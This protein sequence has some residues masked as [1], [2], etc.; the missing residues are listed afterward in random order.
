MTTITLSSHPAISS[1]ETS[2]STTTV[3]S[4]I[5]GVTLKGTAA[6]AYLFGQALRTADGTYFGEAGQR[7]IAREAAA[8]EFPPDSGVRVSLNEVA[9]ALRYK[10]S[11][12]PLIEWSADL[13]LVGYSLAD[14]NLVLERLNTEYRGQ[15]QLEPL[16]LREATKTMEPFTA[17]DGASSDLLLRDLMTATQRQALA[18]FAQQLKTVAQT[19]LD[20]QGSPTDP[21]LTLLRTGLLQEGLALSTTSTVAVPGQTVSINT[22]ISRAGQALGVDFLARFPD[23]FA[24][25]KLRL[26]DVNLLLAAAREAN[27]ARAN[28]LADLVPTE[29]LIH[30]GVRYTGNQAM[31]LHS[32]DVLSGFRLAATTTVRQ[33]AW[34]E[35]VF[36]DPFDSANSLSADDLIQRFASVGFNPFA[37]LGSPRPGHLTVLDLNAFL[38]Q[39]NSDLG[40]SA[41]SAYVPLVALVDNTGQPVSQQQAYLDR[42]MAALGSAAT[43]SALSGSWSATPYT[44]ATPVRVGNMVPVNYV[45]QADNSLINLAESLRRRISSPVVGRVYVRE[46]YDY[47]APPARFAAFVWTGSGFQPVTQVNA[48]PFDASHLADIMVYWLENGIEFDGVSFGN[49]AVNL[50]D[51]G[52]PGAPAGSSGQALAGSPLSLAL[53]YQAALADGIFPVLTGDNPL[54]ING[55]RGMVIPAT[56]TQIDATL[57]ALFLQNGMA[58]PPYP[59]AFNAPSVSRIS[60]VDSAGNTA[61][62]LLPGV[63]YKAVVTLSS[64]WPRSNIAAGVTN[65]ANRGLIDGG[66][67]LGNLNW[68]QKVALDPNLSGYIGSMPYT[69]PIGVTWRAGVNPGFTPG[70]DLWSPVSGSNGLGFQASFTVT[71]TTSIPASGA[72][73]VDIQ[74][75]QW[76]RAVIPG[77]VIDYPITSRTLTDWEVSPQRFLGWSGALPQ[78]QLLNSQALNTA[79][80]E[81]PSGSGTRVSLAALSQA[82]SRD[83]LGSP[84]GGPDL[85]NWFMG[86]GGAYSG[87]NRGWAGG[88][89][90]VDS[91][92][93]GYLSGSGD[94]IPVVGLGTFTDPTGAK[95]LSEWSIKAALFSLWW[96]FEVTQAKGDHPAAPANTAALLPV[97]SGPAQIG[98][99]A[100]A[101]LTA[102]QTLG[103][104]KL[105]GAQLSAFHQLSARRF[106]NDNADEL[107]E[108]RRAFRGQ[109]SA[110]L[111][112][113]DL[114]GL[115]SSSV[116]TL[117]AAAPGLEAGLMDARLLHRLAFGQRIGFD[118]PVFFN[119]QGEPASLSML[120]GGRNS[121]IT[122]RLL[123]VMPQLVDLGLTFDDLRRVLGTAGQAATD[124]APVTIGDPARAAFVVEGSRYEGGA[125][126]LLRIAAALRSLASGT[127]ASVPLDAS[128]RVFDDPITPGS[129]IRWSFTD[130]SLLARRSAGYQGLPSRNGLYDTD[131]DAMVRQL[132]L[133]AGKVSTVSLSSA[134]VSN[135]A[136]AWFVNQLT[137]PSGVSSLALNIDA[138]AA[139]FSSGGS[140]KSFMA[141]LADVQRLFGAELAPRLEA[142]GILQ[143]GSRVNVAAL[144]RLIAWADVRDAAVLSSAITI[145][146]APTSGSMSLSVYQQSVA[147]VQVALAQMQALVAPMAAW[148]PMPAAAT[149]EQWR[150]TQQR[151]AEL[152]G[153]MDA[154]AISLLSPTLETALLGLQTSALSPVSSSAMRT[155]IADALTAVRAS[156]AD[157]ED[158]IQDDMNALDVRS[159]DLG[160]VMGSWTFAT[161]QS[162]AINAQRSLVADFN[163]AQ[164]AIKAAWQTMQ[165][166]TGGLVQPASVAVGSDG[167]RRSGT[168]ASAVLL[169]QALQSLSAPSQVLTSIDP[170]A[171]LFDDPAAWASL[172]LR[173]TLNSASGAPK[174]SL[175]Q[176][177]ARGESALGFNFL[178]DYA[179]ATGQP[180]TTARVNGLIQ[181]MNNALGYSA[182]ALYNTTSYPPVAVGTAQ[183]LRDKI[184]RSATQELVIPAALRSPLAA[185]LNHV[186]DL[187]SA[188]I[189][190]TGFF[191]A[192]AALFDSA[193]GVAMPDLTFNQLAQAGNGASPTLA[194]LLSRMGIVVAGQVN[195]RGLNR[196]IDIGRAEMP[197]LVTVTPMALPAAVNA[198]AA[199]ATMTLDDFDSFASGNAD[200]LQILDEFQT[201]I[202]E[203]K[204][205]DLNR[206]VAISEWQPWKDRILAVMDRADARGIT[207]PLDRSKVNDLLAL[208]EPLV[209]WSAPQ[210]WF[211]TLKTRITAVI[212][213]VNQIIASAGTPPL[214][215]DLTTYVNSVKN[216]VLIPFTKALDSVN[217]LIALTDPQRVGGPLSLPAAIAAEKT[218][219]AGV[220]VNW[221]GSWIQNVFQVPPASTGAALLTVSG[222]GPWRAANP[223]SAGFDLLDWLHTFDMPTA[224]LP[225][226]RIPA[227]GP[228]PADYNMGDWLNGY[229]GAQDYTDSMVGLQGPIAVFNAFEQAVTSGQANLALNPAMGQ[230]VFAWQELAERLMLRS[231]TVDLPPGNQALWYQVAHALQ[232]VDPADLPSNGSGAGEPLFEFPPGSGQRY[233]LATFRDKINA[234]IAAEQD[235]PAVNRS[236]NTALF[237]VINTGGSYNNIAD[238]LKAKIAELKANGS[239]TGDVLYQLTGGVFVD[240]DVDRS[241]GSARHRALENASNS[242]QLSLLRGL[243]ERNTL[244]HTQMRALV[245]EFLTRFKSIY[246][247]IGVTENDKWLQA[248]AL[249]EGLQQRPASHVGI[250]ANY[251]ISELLGV[252]SGGVFNRADVYWLQHDWADHPITTAANRTLLIDTLQSYLDSIPQ[253]P[254]EYDFFHN[255]GDRLNVASFTAADRSRWLAAIY[256]AMPEVG[257]ALAQGTEP[258]LSVADRAVVEQMAAAVKMDLDSLT[259][260]PDLRSQPPRTELELRD[261]LA[262]GADIYV[263]RDGAFYINGVR[264]RPMDLAVT[265]RFLAQDKLAAEYKV[266]MDE[267]SERNN[268]IGAARAVIDTLDTTTGTDAQIRTALFNKIYPLQTQL[269]SS[270]LLLELTGGKYYTADVASTGVPLS[271]LSTYLTTLKSRAQSVK[272]FYADRLTEANARKLH[273]TT[274][275]FSSRY[276]AEIVAVNAKISTYTTLKD[277]A[278]LA[279]SKCTQLLGSMTSDTPQD[280]LTKLGGGTFDVSS[281]GQTYSDTLAWLRRFDIDPSLLQ[282]DPVT[283]TFEV[284]SP[285]G[286]NRTRTV[287]PNFSLATLGLDPTILSDVIPVLQNGYESTHFGATNIN[288]WRSGTNGFTAAYQGSSVSYRD[289][290]F[291]LN[292]TPVNSVGATGLADIKALLNTLISNKIRDGDLAQSKLQ[293]LTAQIQN[294]I[295]AMSALIKVF[296]ESAKTLAQALR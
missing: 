142:L 267:M 169:A 8:F 144:N 205:R 80:F 4:N 145:S 165:I 10:F 237:N 228:Y 161:D 235:L 52:L 22:L 188:D 37:Y 150:A 170:D 196:L 132:E 98:A 184:V 293:A 219:L 217:N 247:Q 220:T 23:I 243:L 102:E 68:A 210:V 263:N 186:A 60:Y 292:N 6:A 49:N 94:L 108:L 200:K 277:E 111:Q 290:Q 26:E 216:R 182:S 193:P 185:L 258:E 276:D 231:R 65:A 127:H 180:W 272:D 158:K 69:N 11:C 90:S 207:L 53:P 152:Y 91:A 241:L 264:T 192:S 15:F 106:G 136:L 251:A 246:A 16:S 85:V 43:S 215:N 59:H 84:A 107:A 46:I 285:F 291:S 121:L 139:T 226:I 113:A 236:A 230:P 89:S 34:S 47:N 76:L 93:M 240:A 273:Y 55:S 154:G 294:N 143:G 87:S 189:S 101:A 257:K 175:R 75:N 96:A 160:S 265:T 212:A 117:A 83:I 40:L 13:G 147:P 271:T 133:V 19:W 120:L 114:S 50:M 238:A 198:I 1:W 126:V 14:I 256:Q 100:S 179:P 56:L 116:A 33:I 211:G 137:L 259:R 134:A 206:L 20:S 218:R 229:P 157:L 245:Q 140:T 138:K 213:D 104:V 204:S 48:M 168:E 225:T 25:G 289:S 129:G 72:V 12:D 97:A 163:A 253:A 176:L 270:D 29:G 103:V 118:E 3:N 195:A 194:E 208:T 42:L 105:T 279:V 282:A 209:A 67:F 45:E 5:A 190:N 135:E 119:A 130:L 255:L 286:F 112:R 174:I 201:L 244:T 151:L 61:S 110:S 99:V 252:A 24:G 36:A 172:A 62:T 38:Q 173:Q 115:S 177:A 41:A 202:N 141:L 269:G 284:F 281:S 166:G 181:L 77:G 122:Q 125:A 183:A 222:G 239:A 221:E 81:Y 124:S 7:R 268:L 260:S 187:S 162:A 58:W 261:D 275:N 287:S 70:A 21:L 95:P 262:S 203:W 71:A 44:A 214:V 249:L 54:T 57:Q 17:L 254:A 63:T 35:K 164:G 9:D 227:V 73:L 197:G 109:T 232:E 82:L 32:A 78:N 278:D 66:G 92:A 233:T 148:S 199:Q 224:F 18:D 28:D 171:A 128:A 250:S 51:Y 248:R 295:E 155:A 31:L 79:L 159:L 2:T 283:V 178:T 274:Y 30:K 39:V 146:P 153:R 27:P 149:T 86:T 123:A 88:Y 156:A 131:L 167:V 288:D 191:S 223:L 280:F 242:D 266:L 64:P 234:Q 296:S 74:N